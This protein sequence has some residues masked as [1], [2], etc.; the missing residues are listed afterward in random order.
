VHSLPAGQIVQTVFPVPEAY[1]PCGHG[2]GGEWVLRQAWPAGQLVHEVAAPNEYWPEL[3][4][5]IV[6]VEQAYPG[7]QSLQETLFPLG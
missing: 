7:S 6:V 4:A 5:D 2:E 1:Q 3:H